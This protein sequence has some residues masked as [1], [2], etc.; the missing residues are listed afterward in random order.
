MTGTVSVFKAGN[1]PAPKSR[2][3]IT[4]SVAEHAIRTGMTEACRRR[5][6]RPVSS[7]GSRVTSNHHSTF[8]RNRLDK[9]S[10]YRHLAV[11][12]A[13]IAAST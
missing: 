10:A 4:A 12:A 6:Q 3:K 13:S 9:G 2:V 1:R 8:A 7:T 11:P 5:R